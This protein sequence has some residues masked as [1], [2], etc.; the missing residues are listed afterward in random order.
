MRPGPKA[1]TEES[2]GSGGDWGIQK[3]NEV[4]SNFNVNESLHHLTAVLLQKHTQSVCVDKGGFLNFPIIHILCKKG[5]Y[6]NI[7]YIYNIDNII[8][9]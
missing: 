7:I 9:I 4:R 2:K 1:V 8:I 5:L 6:I 3:N